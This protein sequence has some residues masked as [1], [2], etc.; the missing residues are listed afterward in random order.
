M[1]H[2]LVP[3]K[4]F[5]YKIVSIS[6]TILR[7]HVKVRYVYSIQTDFP[8]HVSSR[9]NINVGGT[10]FSNSRL[11]ICQQHWEFSIIRVNMSLTVI[12]TTDEVHEYQIKNSCDIGLRRKVCVITSD[13]RR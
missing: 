9:I 10:V 13:C 8:R 7:W 2:I 4:I 5:S 12:P 6:F 11:N 3:V 1:E